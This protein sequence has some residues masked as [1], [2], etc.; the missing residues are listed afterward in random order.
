MW[1]LKLSLYLL[2]K[3]D[4]LLFPLDEKGV[5]DYDIRISVMEAIKGIEYII[6]E[7]K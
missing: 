6:E 4:D 7:E 3:V 2:N 1:K 5:I